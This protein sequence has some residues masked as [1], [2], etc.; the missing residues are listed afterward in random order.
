ML[1]LHQ[2]VMGG[3][4]DC[5]V[6]TKKHDFLTNTLAFWT[7][8]PLMGQ[9]LPSEPG[10]EPRVS[11]SGKPNSS[12]EIFRVSAAQPRADPWSAAEA[13]NVYAPHRRESQHVDLVVTE[14]CCNFPM[15]VFSTTFLIAVALLQSLS[16]R[17]TMSLYCRLSVSLG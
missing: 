1:I 11:A 12:L 2:A 10:H 4:I 15:L 9:A 8:F 16:V 13:R 3:F 14:V 7:Y 17:S 6:G 5:S